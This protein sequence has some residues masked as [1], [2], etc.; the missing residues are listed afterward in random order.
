MTSEDVS[1]VLELLR[2]LYKRTQTLQ[3]FAD[4]VVFRD[5]RRA[6][7]LQPSDSIVFQTFVRAVF[8]CSDEELREVRSSKQIC[9]F[10]ELLAF[11]LN[12][13]KRSKSNNVLAQGYNWKT[14]Q[15]NKDVNLFRFQGDLSQSA[16]YIHS[17][18]QWKKVMAHLGP[19]FLLHLLGS[20]SVFVVAPP[21]CVFQICGAPAY[22]RVSVTT[23]SSRFLLK[24]PSRRHTSSWLGKNRCSVKFKMRD[25]AE[26]EEKRRKKRRVESTNS[27]MKRKREPEEEESSKR[28]CDTHHEE[29]SQH[30]CSEAV[31]VESTVSENDKSSLKMPPETSA[32]SLPLE[33]EP[34]WRSGTFP[35]LPSS[36]CFI[37]TMGLLYGG[38]G[39]QGFCLNR[40][41]Q[42][43]AGLRRLQGQDLV[44][45]VFFQGL[46]YLDKQTR[47]PKKLRLRFFRMV[48]V[49]GELLQRHRKCPYTRVLQRMCPLVEE[50]RAAPGQPSSLIP[51]H[52]DPHR[53]YLFVRACLITVVPE[54]LWGS[55]HN[56][57]QF[58]TKV[59]CFLK[60]GK[61]ERVSVA[62][63]M[64]KMK[65][66]DCDWLKLRRTGRFPP[67][68]LTYRTQILS[69]FL[70]WLL[71]GFVVGLVQACFYATDSV[72]QK[73]TIRFYRPE[74][75][76]KLRDLA[77]RN[78]VAKGQMEELT[79]DQVASLPKDA[80]ISQL[81]FIPKAD[82]MRPITRVIRADL[83]TR[84][85]HWCIRD[86]M[87][88]LQAR[89]RSMPSLL[90]STVW[91]LTD[92]H[93]VLSSLAPAQKAKPQ[94][95]YFVKVDVSGAYESLPH[96]KLKQV[97]SE[98]LSPIQEQVFAIRRYAK[99]W[100][101]SHEGVKKTFTKQVDFSDGDLGSSTMKNFT[102][103]LQQISN[104][105]HSV[106][107]EQAFTSNIQGKDA[108]QV[109]MQMLTGSIVQ[110]ENKTYRQ[111]RGIPQG[112]VVSSLLCCLCYGHME[113]VLFRDLSKNSGCLMRLVDDFLLIT[114]DLNQ[115]HTFLRIFLAGVPQYGVVA[116][117]QKV[118]VN[119]QPSEFGDAFT[120]VRVLPSHCLFPWCGLLL[121]T[122]SLDVYKD[123]SSYAGLSLRYS[124]TL[125]STHLPG[126]HMRRKLMSI[127]RLKC[128]PLFLDLKMNSHESVYK[129]I[130]KL[131]LLHACRFHVCAQSLPFSQTVAKNPSYFLQMIW[132]M[133][134]YA[135]TLIRRCNRG[136]VLGDKAQTGSVQF[137]AV[138][139]LFCLC[140]QLVLSKHR[141]VYRD[142]L[143]HLDKCKRHMERLL[144]DLRLARVQ[145]AS[146][147]RALLDFLQM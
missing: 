134:R 138:K 16:N 65:V 86:L 51:L 62:E 132:D 18:E 42:T 13:L 5:G 88:L 11:V 124:L 77:F 29:S 43:A 141:P 112:S 67:S 33:G 28:R 91:G 111:C 41:K 81:R 20:F 131:V 35:P 30:A 37:R 100:R 116:N 71:D 22:D 66:M 48:P 74:V 73:S 127:L 130:Y 115:A 147:P 117:P 92:I 6:T 32:A 57:L 145:Q 53:V 142:L 23:A 97:V 50:S 133:V 27:S 75:W 60:N 109:F 123:Y 108:V 82:G 83:H 21:S 140:F 120:D 76:N 14:A 52:C 79:P 122:Q 49:F 101:D 12:N 70:T 68:E 107:V 105:H 128:H 25:S 102:M 78:H 17:S 63:L 69:L 58:F 56:R 44:R 47:D 114:P 121:D 26:D 55:D 40:K 85:H 45:L 110:Y 8:V 106:L 4:G 80:I 89:V 15:E 135:N 59:R 34:S 87:D 146:D 84:L 143:P 61:F 7:L 98:A 10:S 93:K 90:G 46:P 113:R 1:R 72:G 2:S 136:L 144:G 54:E 36:Q 139:L 3:E 118:V 9:T 129:N 96:D 119:F 94:Q 38:Q 39:M 24:H 64:W 19:D 137:E 99:I 103:A 126:Q 125:G 104:A 31:L 95:L